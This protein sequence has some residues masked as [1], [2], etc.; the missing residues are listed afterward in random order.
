MQG[1]RGPP[2]QGQLGRAHPK[3]HDGRAVSLLIFSE[4]GLTAR[5][6]GHDNGPKPGVV[7]ERSRSAVAVKWP[8]H[9]YY[10]G[11]L[12]GRPYA[13]ARVEVFRVVEG[14]VTDRSVEVESVINWNPSIKYS[15]L[16]QGG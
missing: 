9:T 1:P 2:R 6:S 4:D 16:P 12:G 7:L 13:P 15:G 11:M 3:I 14:S 10:G 8:G 5:H